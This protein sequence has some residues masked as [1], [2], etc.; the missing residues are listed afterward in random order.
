MITIREETIINTP[1]ESVFDFLVNF[2]SL[3]KTWHPKD[4]VFCKTISGSLSKKGCVF[5]FLE[6]I[7]GF[8]VYLI[9][10]ITAVKENEYLEYSLAFP[11]SL[12]RI[13]KGYFGI[14]NFSPGQSKLVAYF[15]YGDR[16]GIFDRVANFFVKTFAAQKHLKEEGENIKKYLEKLER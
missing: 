4:H 10:K 11:F 3:Y 13:G 2:D 12:L 14:E 15:E 8:P 6:I 1:A 5:H 7:G 9:V 16:F